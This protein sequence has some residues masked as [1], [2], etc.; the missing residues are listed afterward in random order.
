MK[1]AFEFSFLQ[2]LQ[3][4]GIVVV[5]SSMTTYVVEPCCFLV[6]DFRDSTWRFILESF[7]DLSE[8]T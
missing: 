4:E 1:P 5:Y 3:R 7:I 8:T 6:A 2:C